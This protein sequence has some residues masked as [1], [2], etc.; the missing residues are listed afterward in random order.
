[1]LKK[2][3]A[4]ILLA[5]FFVSCEFKDVDFRG[6]ESYKVEKFENNELFLNVSF[7][8]LNENG[9]KLKVKPSKLDLLVEDIEMGELILDKKIIFKKKSE[10]LYTTVL[11]IKLANGAMLSA[12]K[13]MSKKELRIRVK[14]KVKASAFCLSKKLPVDETKMVSSKDFNFRDF[15]K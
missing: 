12:M 1:M 15:L 7:K 8:L 5:T 10:G 14:G 3:S 2:I 4:I 6:L 13:F 9:F 11:R